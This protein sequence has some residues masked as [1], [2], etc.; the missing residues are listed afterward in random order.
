MKLKYLIIYNLVLLICL[1]SFG[2]NMGYL[3]RNEYV[4]NVKVPSKTKYHA[5][6]KVLEVSNVTIAPQFSNLSFVYRVSNTNYTRDYYNIF[7]NSPAQQIEQLIIKYLRSENLFKYIAS[8]ASILPP[9]YILHSEIVAFCADYRDFK[10]PKAVIAIRFILFNDK[11]RVLMN[12]M[13][14][15]AVALQQKDTRSLVYAWDAGLEEIL[16]QLNNRLHNL[17]V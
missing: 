17:I 10:R 3:Q 11:T 6:N 13:F 9:N 4:L 8:D 15:A 12:K 5:S 16:E 7:F 1:T 14:S 2:C